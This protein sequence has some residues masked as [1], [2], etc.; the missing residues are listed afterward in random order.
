MTSLETPCSPSPC[1]TNAEC[2]VGVRNVAV[3]ICLEGNAHLVKS[4][5]NLKQKIGLH[6]SDILCVSYKQ[7]CRHLEK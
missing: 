5:L 6:F 2:S 4:I 7:K 1:G 3:C